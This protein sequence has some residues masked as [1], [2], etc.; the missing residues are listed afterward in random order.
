MNARAINTVAVIIPTFRRQEKLFSLLDDLKGNT[1]VPDEIVVVDNDPNETLE[2]SRGCIARGA[3]YIHLGRGLFLS[4]ARN[5]GWRA[6]T[7]DLCIFIDDDNILP[8]NFIANYID[9]V[10]TYPHLG[11]IAPI[12]HDLSET[13]RVWYAGIRRSMWTTRTRFLYQEGGLPALDLWPTDDAPDVFAMPRHVLKRV[14]GFDE[15]HF[16][17][18]YDEADIGERVRA[19]G[20]KVAVVPTLTVTHAVTRIGVGTEFARAYTLGG[21]ERIRL[22]M[23]GR[24]WFHRRHSRGLTRL[25][26]LGVFVPGYVAVVVLACAMAAAPLSIKTKAIL[27]I[28]AGVIAGYWT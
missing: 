26:A 5:A 28:P 3:Q 16:P 12:I 17:F 22:M 13:N 25:V 23:R 1:R 4:G 24:I 7:S 21:E 27:A 6:T 18:H 19:A 2:L 14:D 15:M 20:F 11:I 10:Q 8:S 9:A